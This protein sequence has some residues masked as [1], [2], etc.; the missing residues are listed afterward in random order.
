MATQIVAGQIS[1]ELEY[2]WG[3]I[4]GLDNILSQRLIMS[5]ECEP[6]N[7]SY[8]R[9]GETE[10]LLRRL[11]TGALTDDQLL[12]FFLKEVHLLLN[13]EEKARLESKMIGGAARLLG[14]D[15]QP[16]SD[17][18]TDWDQ[19]RAE[20]QQ[21]VNWSDVPVQ[22]QELS[23]RR[24]AYILDY[25]TEN[26]WVERVGDTGEWQITEHGRSLLERGGFY[27]R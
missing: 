7:N 1:E 14:F 24:A 9:D 12:R 19:R 6:W 21:E 17:A 18:V 2:T 13:P 4:S 25:V 15:L 11:L 3:S 8:E 5:E 20:L 22:L 10:R 26:R 23:S 27:M 16:F